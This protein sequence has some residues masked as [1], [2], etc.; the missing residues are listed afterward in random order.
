MPAIEFLCQFFF[1][2]AP[3]RGAIRD[4]QLQPSIAN[5]SPRSPV[6]ALDRQ[7]QPSIASSSPRSPIP[8]LDRQFQPSIASS[9]HRSPVPV[10]DRP[11]T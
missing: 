8:A 11:S 4:R 5:S 9:S 2:A 7:F 3:L 1:S 6:P 10:I